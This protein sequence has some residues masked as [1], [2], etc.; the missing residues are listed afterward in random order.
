VDRHF[1]AIPGLY[2]AGELC[3][4]AGGHVNGKQGLGGTML[5]PSVFSGRVAGAW[6]AAAAGH[7]PGFRGTPDRR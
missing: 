4:M 1:Q 5:G 3:G 6:A 7:G 2:A